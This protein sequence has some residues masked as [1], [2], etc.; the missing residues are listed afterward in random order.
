MHTHRETDDLNVT[1]QDGTSLEVAQRGKSAPSR[2]LIRDVASNL[3]AL[4]R[5]LPYA[6]Y[7]AIVH[8]IA[9]VRMRC[10][11]RLESSSVSDGNASG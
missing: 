11:V 10:E 2:E 1:E 5:V 9:E 4:A 8:R 7:A 3:K 6:E